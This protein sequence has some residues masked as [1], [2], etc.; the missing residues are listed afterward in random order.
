ML[1]FGVHNFLTIFSLSRDH[2]FVFVK[3]LAMVLACRAM[4]LWES[5]KCVSLSAGV[6]SFCIVRCSK[7]EKVDVF[8]RAYETNKHSLVS[9]SNVLRRHCLYVQ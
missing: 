7:K 4:L 2:V 6:L 9:F 1:D 8:F 5:T 3:F